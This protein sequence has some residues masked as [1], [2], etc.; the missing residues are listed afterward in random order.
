M[1]AYLVM[2]LHLLAVV[3]WIGGQILLLFVVRP[4]LSA[5]GVPPDLLGLVGRRFRTL[6][7]VSVIILILT[8]AFNILNEGGSARIESP[9]GGVLMLKLLLVAAAV[10]LTL[11]H[12]FI[13]DPYAAPSRRQTSAP[14]NPSTTGLVQ[15]IVLALSLA[16]LLIAAYLAR[17]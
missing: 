16:I 3:T 9:W 7:W 4:A 14:S 2:W 5:P 1:P 15:F 6:T 11:V 13:M 12:D 17:M 10:G 8:G